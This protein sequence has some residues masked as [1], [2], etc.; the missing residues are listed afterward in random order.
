MAVSRDNGCLE[1]WRRAIDLVGKPPTKV[2][3]CDLG[4]Q[5]AK[6][7]PGELP[8]LRR[9]TSLTAL[10]SWFGAEA[11][12]IDRNGRD[13]ALPLDLSE[14]VPQA[15]HGRFDLVTDF[16][17]LEHVSANQEQAFRNVHDLAKVG[18]VIVHCLPDPET[19]PWHGVWNY[20]TEWFAELAKRC[21]YDLV[22]L[23]RWFKKATAVDGEPTEKPRRRRRRRPVNTEWYVRVLMVKTDKSAFVGPW[24]QPVGKPKPESSQQATAT[25]EAKPAPKAEPKVVMWSPKKYT[26]TVSIG[27]ES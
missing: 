15:L 14:P 10:W 25:F 11:V 19:R 20:T 6:C 2:A 24:V 17:T 12:C 26:K 4:N 5:R 7:V 3:V 8:G 22:H 21:S 18:G 23:E 16:G 13:N 1:M 27:P 9:V